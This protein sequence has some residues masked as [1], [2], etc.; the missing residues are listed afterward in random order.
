MRERITLRR[1]IKNIYSFVM[2]CYQIPAIT[3]SEF[4]GSVTS[5]TSGYQEKAKY[6]RKCVRK[7][8]QSLTLLPPA[9]ILF[10]FS[11]F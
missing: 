8:A 6:E 9:N 1:P 5:R 4:T 11:H 2:F 3:R 10:I 7:R